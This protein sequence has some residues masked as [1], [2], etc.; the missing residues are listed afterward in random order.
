MDSIFLGSILLKSSESVAFPLITNSGLLFALDEPSQLIE[1]STFP[2]PCLPEI[3]LIFT[4]EAAPR[5]EFI[6]SL[7]PILFAKP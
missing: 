7:F 1:I 5:I 3:E 4:P 6:A 2:E